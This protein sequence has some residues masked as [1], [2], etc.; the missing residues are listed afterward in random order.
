MRYIDTGSRREDQVLGRWLME[1]TSEPITEIRLQSGFFAAEALGLLVHTFRNLASE[2]GLVR[3]LIGSNKGV[4][5]HGDVRLLAEL[6]GLPRPNADLGIVRYSNGLFH[7]KVYHLT[8]GDGSRCAYVGSS[9]LT[10][11]GLSEHVEAGILL[12]TRDDDPE[13]VINSISEAIDEWFA[14]DRDGFFRVVDIEAVNRLLTEGILLAARPPSPRSTGNSGTGHSTGAVL[15]R[16]MELPPVPGSSGSPVSEVDSPTPPV[17][18]HPVVTRDGFPWNILF[19]EGATAPTQGAMALSGSTLPGG[20]VG[21]I[22]RLSNDNARHFVGGTGT[23]NI[24][25]PVPTRLTLRFGVRGRGRYPDRPRAEYRLLLRYVGQDLTLNFPDS[26]LTNVMTYGQFTEESSHGDVRMVLP[27][28]V[29]RLGD[30]IQ[31]QGL[32]VPTSRDLALLEWPTMAAPEF[33]LSFVQ[34]G[35][36]LYQQM[37]TL[38]SDAEASHQLVGHG[39][40]WLPTA[41]APTWEEV[42]Q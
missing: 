32:P 3:I 38:F 6:L 24:S 2:N 25:I 23:A 7:P 20:N 31:R 11:Q 8:R 42:N 29:R 12:D 4:T 10:P 21:L 19:S 16:L 17:T 34:R 26:P 18:T 15:Q 27:A 14:G 35:S 22:L 5:L 30:A 37:E 33:R 1:V 36:N 40:C 9:N 28:A 39:A 13:D 41:L